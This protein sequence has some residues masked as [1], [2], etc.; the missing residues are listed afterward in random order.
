VQAADLLGTILI[1]G[2]LAVNFSLVMNLDA[3][4]SPHARK[5][6]GQP[7]YSPSTP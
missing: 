5:R 2:E 6:G 1:C 4:W 7:K 3:T